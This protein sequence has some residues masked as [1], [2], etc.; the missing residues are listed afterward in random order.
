MKRTF[1]LNQVSA[2]EIIEE[3]PIK[4][5]NSDAYLLRHKKTGAH[6]ALLSND[7]DNKVFYIGFRTPPFDSTGVAHIVE[8][9]VL[10]GSKD[11]PLKDPFV[12]LIKGSLNTFLN[13]MT[14]PDKTVYPVASCNDADFR[15]LMHVYL[16]AVFYPNIYREEK[17]FMQEGWHYEMENEDDA[18]KI[19]GVV[20][21]EMKGAFS[22]P[23]EVLERYIK[24][25][26]FPD[27]TYGIESGGDPDEIPNLTYEDFLDFHKRYYHPSNSYIY[28]YGDMDM[29]EQLTYIDEAY[30]SKFE[31][32]EPDSEVQMQKDFTEPKELVKTYSCLDEAEEENGTFLSYNVKLADCFDKERYIAFSTLDYALCSAPG[33]VLK[34]ALID[35]GIGEDVYSS[36]SSELKQPIFSVIAKNASS[37]QKEEFLQTIK[38]VLTKVVN[39]GIDKK[40]LMA[41]LNVEEFQ[42]REA[43]YGRFPRGLAYG[44]QMLDSWLHDDQSAWNHIEANATFASLKK[45]VNEGYFEELTKTYLLD[46]P[47][48]TVFV[49]EPKARLAMQK[50]AELKEALEKK[51]AAMSKEEI[52]EI[53]DDTKAL[54]AYQEEEPTQEELNSIPLLKMEDLKKTAEEFK[55][56]E[57]T[58]GTTPVL[59]HDFFTNGI[60]YLNFSFDVSALPDDLVDSLVLFKAALGMLDTKHYS[61]AELNNE[62]FLKTGGFSASLSNYPSALQ[63]EVFEPRFEV[64][65]KVLRENRAEAFR[66]AEE[67]LMTTKWD[68]VKRLKEIVDEVKAQMSA[69][70][71]SAGSQTAALRSL[72]HFSAQAALTERVTG[73]SALRNLERVAKELEEGKSDKIVSNL[74]E[75]ASVIFNSASLL[76]DVTGNEEMYEGIEEEITSFAGALHKAPART[77]E[78]VF[79][80]KDRKEAFMTGGQVQYVCRAGNF[81]KKG[82]PFTGA[83]RVLKVILGYDYLWN[84]IRVKG[85]AYG[86]GS[87]FARTGDAYF[88]TFRDPHLSRSIEVFEDAPAYIR[89]LQVD[90][91]AAL[92]YVI[93]ALSEL[94]MPKTPAGKGAYGMSAY[95]SHVSME[96]LQKEREELMNVNEETI[97]ALADY[98]D[99]FLADESLAVV[100]SAVKVEE[101]KELFDKVEQLI[102]V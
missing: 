61:Y 8:H 27:T 72:S 91:R 36:Y 65:V 6:I 50:E 101:K 46:N 10:C 69:A 3:R 71:S 100:G 56:E 43:D 47:H 77:G 17:I 2:Y 23:D 48:R 45:K 78:I 64:L 34:Q 93:G 57:R 63:P 5:L 58:A 20:Y 60:V 9:T 102:A 15:N 18:L 35:K 75:L 13:A 25:S 82:H 99:A 79:H 68:D 81:L 96:M 24:H 28:L 70:L 80:A 16:D 94:D 51:K 98:I 26:L 97:H 14:Y 83:L 84:N 92:K 33:A 95:L 85:G 74:K 44:L 21:N 86:C 41:A 39:E 22:S 32:M 7:D 11:F 1:D 4:D 29:A 55:Y 62:I 49:L 90:E 52:K 67:I 42:Y 54:R 53:I 88:T 59:F 31:R 12:E 19:N 87:A 89:A 40:T 38:E 66:L 37:D 73:V 76:V 30:L